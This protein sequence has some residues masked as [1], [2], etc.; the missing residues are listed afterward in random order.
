MHG[1]FVNQSAIDSH[2]K[3]MRV[4]GSRDIRQRRVIDPYNAKASS[5]LKEYDTYN[6]HYA[7]GAHSNAFTHDSTHYINQSNEC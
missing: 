5:D 2:R 7:S 1:K 6:L 4:N 3:K